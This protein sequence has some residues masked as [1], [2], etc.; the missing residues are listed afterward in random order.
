MQKLTCSWWKRPSESLCRSRLCSTMKFLTLNFGL[1]SLSLLDCGLIMALTFLDKGRPS[2]MNFW[3]QFSCS[4]EKNHGRQWTETCRVSE[5]QWTENT[6]GKYIAASPKVLEWIKCFLGWSISPSFLCCE[7]G[8][9]SPGPVSIKDYTVKSTFH[10]CPSATQ[11]PFLQAINITHFLC[12]LSRIFY[13]YVSKYMPMYI[14]MCFPSHS[15]LPIGGSQYKLHSTFPFSTLC[16]MSWRAFHIHAWVSQ[17]LFRG[18]IAFRHV[19]AL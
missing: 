3:F 17:F 15:F 16:N 7:K 4:K 18:C 14:C 6:E 1:L 10:L 19:D 12:F 8:P 5:K 2:Q 9:P 13:L 11:F